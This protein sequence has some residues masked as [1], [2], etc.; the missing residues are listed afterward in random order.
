MKKEKYLYRI[1][2][3]MQPKKINYTIAKGAIFESQYSIT[4][5]KINLN[6]S[7]RKQ[8]YEENV[9]CDDCDLIILLI[10]I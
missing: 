4:K 2:N 1:K 3:N 8:C 7:I 6:C 10:S 5:L 9:S